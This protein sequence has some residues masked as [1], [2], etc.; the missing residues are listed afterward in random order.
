MKGVLRITDAA[1]MAI[2]TMVMLASEP[3][4]RFTAAELAE[5]LDVSEAHLAKVLQRLARQHLVR[6]VRGPGGGFTLGRPGGEITLMNVFEA[7][8]GPFRPSDCLMDTQV[9]GEGKCLFGP[10]LAKINR[11]FSEYLGKTS[12]KEIDG[13][14]GL[15]RA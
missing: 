2:H 15:E 5:R 12:V 8:E 14:Y 3:G 6:S 1:T 7:I 9:C 4:R 10:L 13:N 11:E